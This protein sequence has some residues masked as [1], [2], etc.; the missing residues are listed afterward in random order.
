[1]SEADSNETKSS[2]IQVIDRA[3]QLLRALKETPGGLTQAE[4]SDRLGLPKTTIHRILSAL[5]EAEMVAAGPGTRARYRLG[6]EIMRLASS[7]S[8]D[9]VSLIHPWLVE[10]SGRL[11]ETVDLS[12]LDGSV[13]TFIDQV[14]APHR[15]RAA[16]A[17]GESFPL[18]TCAPGKALLATL[19]PDELA[20][21]VPARLVA[22]TQ[23]TITS[24]SELRQQL[25]HIRSVGVAYDYE[26][27]NEGICAA[28]IAAAVGGIPVAIS[29]PMPAQRF[30]G[31]EGECAKA[32][33][34]LRDR[35]AAADWS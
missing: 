8:R 15:L 30:V 22:S 10:L 17:V 16:S 32:L 24:V 11:T 7:S 23:H 4:L 1:V 29:V 6:P 12:I 5:E 3:V 28:G 20:H 18:H 26:E 31:R 9:L 21:I 2:G 25:E 35:I 19:S 13:I 14:E 27:Q 34:D 33:L